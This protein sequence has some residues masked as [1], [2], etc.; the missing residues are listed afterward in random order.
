MGRCLSAPH[1]FTIMTL[2]MGKQISVSEG[3]KRDQRKLFEIFRLVPSIPYSIFCL[4]ICC[5]SVFAHTNPDQVLSQALQA[6]QAG[7]LEEAA[8][9]YEKFLSLRP[10]R[11]DIR[12]NLGAVLSRLGRYQEAIEQYQRALK[13]DPGNYAIRFN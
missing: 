7:N 8:R 6:H 2:I 1:F 13:L 12:S 4:A 10:E 11:A 9:A 5:L 3:I